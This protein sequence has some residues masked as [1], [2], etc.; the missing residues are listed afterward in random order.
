MISGEVRVQSGGNAYRFLGFFDGANLVV[1]TNAFAKK[2]QKTPV[3][4]IA[5]ARERRR[6]YLNRKTNNG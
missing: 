2:Q 6:D 1:L 4:E 5:L 3:A